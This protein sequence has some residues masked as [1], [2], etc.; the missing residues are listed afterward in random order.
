MGI[1]MNN[2]I[3]ILAIVGPTASSKTALSLELAEKFNAE[4]I[5]GDSMQ[6]YKTLNIATAK[7]S[8]DEL[9]KIRH[10]MIDIIEPSQNF[11][12][13]D[14]VT[15]AAE[16]ISDVHERGKLPLVVGGTGLYIDSL[17]QNI[18]FSKAGIDEKL[19][20]ELFARDKQDLY[21]ELVTIDPIYAKKLHPN[22]VKRI[23][24]SLE[25]YKLTGITP[26][27]Q[28][29]QSKTIKSPYDVFMIGLDFR[30]R[31]KL[32]QRINLRV[33]KMFEQGLVEEAKMVYNINSKEFAQNENILQNTTTLQEN[34]AFQAKIACHR[35]TAF[36]AKIAC[37]RNTFFQAIGY[38]EFELYFKGMDTLENVIEN[39]K[40]NT[41]NYAKRQLT[42]FR[43]NKNTNWLYVDDYDNYDLLV[44][45]TIEMCKGNF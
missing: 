36:Q 11:N 23:V 5:S 14:Y 15:Q 4:I 43:R 28:A 42:W 1:N 29:A 33:D 7:P 17:L 19:R 9:S 34:T 12:V 10:H 27:E 38:K 3:P 16:V 25:M 35:N 45:K 8:L 26:T 37:C 22:N 32:Y 30:S 18:A 13:Q 20:E 21:N 39:I 44:K 40:Q 41:R 31:E 24:R 2:K 6:V